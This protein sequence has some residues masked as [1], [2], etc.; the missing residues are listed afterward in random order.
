[1]QGKGHAELTNGCI[2]PAG[3]DQTHCSC[4]GT[5]VEDILYSSVLITAAQHT[6]VIKSNQ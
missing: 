3:I 6:K 2:Q 4:Q 1:M 5:Q